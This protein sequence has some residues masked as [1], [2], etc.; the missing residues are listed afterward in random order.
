M[1][2]DRPKRPL[3]ATLLVAGILFQAA[4]GTTG[5]LGLVIDPTGTQLGLPLRSLAGTPFNDYLIPGLILLFVLGVFPLFVLI[6][7][8]IRHPWAWYGAVAVS[9]GL[10]IWIAVEVA[11]IG[12][13][14][15]PPLQLIYGALGLGLLVLTFTPGVRRYYKHPR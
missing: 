7:L 2:S 11:M 14:A 15:E 13:Q 9:V 10:V 5:G 1:Q 3:S 8:W 12:Y 6:G 4:S